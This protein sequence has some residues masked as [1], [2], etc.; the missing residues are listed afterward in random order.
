[1]PLRTPEIINLVHAYN[2][3]NGLTTIHMAQFGQS[4]VFIKSAVDSQTVLI[5][6]LTP[7]LLN[8]LLDYALQFNTERAQVT[9]FDA[10][11]PWIQPIR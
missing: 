11:L 6:K 9:A 1:M 10:R 3:R 2:R 5:A 7:M 8:A 4:F